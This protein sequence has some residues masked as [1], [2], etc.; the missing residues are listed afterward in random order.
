MGFCSCLD[1][2]Q[3]AHLLLS[4]DNP[5]MCCVRP[6]S[7]D[8]IRFFGQIACLFIGQQ[9]GMAER[10]FAMSE[11]HTARKKKYAERAASQPPK[12][13]TLLE[14]MLTALNKI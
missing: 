13:D 8:Q 5:L 6:K 7:Y 2:S 1:I 12:E 3:Y 11:W 4:L 9:F 14:P 10:R